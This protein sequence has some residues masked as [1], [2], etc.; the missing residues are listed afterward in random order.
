MFLRKN[1]RVKDG[2][3]HR[4]YTVVVGDHLKTWFSEQSAGGDSIIAP[5]API[6]MR[7]GQPS[8]VLKAG[9]REPAVDAVGSRFGSNL[10][11]VNQTELVLP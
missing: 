8:I 11:E 5:E 6:I 9:R 4:Y 2:K 1:K 3:E 10:K 7:V